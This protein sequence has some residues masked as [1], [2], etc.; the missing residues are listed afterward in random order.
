MKRGEE[1]AADD[2][3]GGVR[4]LQI[5]DGRRIKMKTMV[6]FAVILVLPNTFELL[7]N[8]ITGKIRR[9]H[10]LFFS[11]LIFALGRFLKISKKIFFLHFLLR[12]NANSNIKEDFS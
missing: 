8:G 6:I 1:M 10:S 3:H 2:W 12:A 4:G 11:S 7:K 5:P 9:K